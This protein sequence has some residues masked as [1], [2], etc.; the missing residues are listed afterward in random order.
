MTK[1]NTN[2]KAEGS[3]MCI[4]IINSP[5]FQDFRILVYIIEYLVSNRRLAGPTYSKR[6]NHIQVG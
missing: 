4:V 1:H 3:Y 6:S 5:C 2:K